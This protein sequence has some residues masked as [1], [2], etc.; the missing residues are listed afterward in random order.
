MMTLAALVVRVGVLGLDK[1]VDV[2]DVWNVR[3]RALVRNVH[4]GVALNLP[5]PHIRHGRQR[6]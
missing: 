3:M 2:H 1:S 6:A 4:P 5:A